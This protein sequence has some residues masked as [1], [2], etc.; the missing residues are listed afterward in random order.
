MSG[1]VWAIIGVVVGAVLSA[2]AQVVSALMQRRWSVSDRSVEREVARQ[3]RTFDHLRD[4][5]TNFLAEAQKAHV[6]ILEHRR[7]KEQS[8]PALL[9]APQVALLSVNVYGSQEAGRAGLDY[10]YALR[11][12]LRA[13]ADGTTK[14]ER[15][16]VRV[17][18]TAYLAELRKDIGVV[19]EATSSIVVRSE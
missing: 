6:Q 13:G 10:V 15:E 14:A 4:A 19:E 12:L 17:T 9:L 7:N 1:E 16:K 5:H 8:A 2:I 11:E 18:R 3:D